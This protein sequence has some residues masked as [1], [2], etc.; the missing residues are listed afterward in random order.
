M[1]KIPETYLYVI[2]TRTTAPFVK[3]LKPKEVLHDYLTHTHTW[4]YR[5]YK[6][7]KLN[8]HW[9]QARGHLQNF[10]CA[11]CMESCRRLC[12]CRNFQ[13]KVERLSR[14]GITCQAFRGAFH[15]SAWCAHEASPPPWGAGLPWMKCLRAR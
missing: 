13:K 7:E 2:F 3:W 11:D 15:C 9:P 10:Y 5:N 14:L 8:L 12:V 6:Q 4:I 1:P